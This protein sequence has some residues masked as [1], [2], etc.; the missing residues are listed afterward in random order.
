MIDSGESKKRK[1]LLIG[2]D[3]ADWK[4][5]NPMIEA[6]EMPALEGLI[7]EGVMGN[8]ATLEPSFSPMLWT[9]IATGKRAHKHGVLGFIEP[10]S[11]GL[12]I[13]PVSV[14][15][16]KVKAIWNIL[17]QE[18]MR[19]HNVGWWPSHPAEP[20]N[21]I[22]ISNA[23]QKAQKPYGQPWR[24]S[25]GTV[26]P[27]K[28][29]RL[30][31]SLRVHPGELTPAHILPFVPHAAKVD[32]DKDKRLVNVAKML[33]ETSTINSAGTWILEN[34]EWDF[35]GMYFDG[36]DHFCHGFMNFHPPRMRNVTDEQFEL[37]QGVVKSAYKFHDMMLDRQLKLA[38]PDAT[39]ILVS[40]HGFHSDHLRPS[41]LSDEPAAPA[42]QHRNYGVIC[43]KGPGIKR[44]ERIYGATLLDVAPTI[45]SL[46]GLPVGEDMDGKT[47]VQAF[48]NRT[49]RKS[50]ESWEEVEGICGMHP[51]D[52]L[53]DPYD[54]SEEIARLVELGYVEEPEKDDKKN[55]EKAVQESRYNLG[56]AY[57]GAGMFTDARAIFEEL[58]KKAPEESRFVLR[59]AS[60]RFEMKEYESCL[61][62][63]TS[64][65]DWLSRDLAERKNNKPEEIDREQIDDEELRKLEE[66]QRKDKLRLLNTRKDLMSLEVVRANVYLKQNEASSAMQIFRKLLSVYPRSKQLNL[67]MG[68]AYINL[69]N[70]EDARKAFETT[71]SIDPDDSTA[72]HGIAICQLRL[73]NY[74]EAIN[75]ALESIALVYHFPFAH[76]HLGEA[77]Y[78]IEEYERA[79][80]AFEVCL[81]INP[82]IGKARNRLVEIYEDK[83]GNPEKAQYHQ[84]YF[85]EEKSSTGSK[86]DPKLK[87]K[88]HADSLHKDLR[89]PVIVVSGLPRS[90]TS[91]MMQMLQGGGADLFTDQER[92]ADESNPKGYLEHEAVKR[93][94]RDASWVKNAK[95]KA[96]KIIARLLFHLPDSNNYKVIFMLRHIDEVINSQQQMLI[97]NN[98]EG[99]KNYP[100][101]LVESYRKTLEKA[102]KWGKNRQNADV[103]YVNYSDVIEDPRKEALRVSEFL[104]RDFNVEGM[105]RAVDKKLY[106]TKV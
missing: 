6:G 102:R 54:T 73:G 29:N 17:M 8:L 15:S 81:A 57:M 59:L 55:V 58:A 64:F 30:F 91:M 60:C 38:G 47:L 7:N 106:R 52:K 43:M 103:I 65:G 13:R 5:I 99:A 34:E 67:N 101:S 25:K 104:G 11:S 53:E 36:I 97:R 72:H 62:I 28:M 66:E 41:F 84:D 79:A 31:A 89:D 90:G 76:Y 98:K 96:V 105:I 18:G 50:I 44:D 35:M 100:T 61:E 27:Q 26:H 9:S 83:L 93:L 20:L 32:Q 23:Y 4:I 95:N 82:S 10:D 48:E 3:A 12:K 49:E 56:R 71:V 16:R 22:S 78:H 87:G 14:V 40:D 75:A 70:W 77:L 92:K 74:Y 51:A 19:V 80:E 1:V 85:L 46:F 88:E 68:R 63:I 33:A 69:K 24:L 21:G 94:A 37:Y 39:I 2:W 45:L 86:A 42:Q